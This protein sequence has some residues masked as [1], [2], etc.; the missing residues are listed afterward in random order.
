LII[1]IAIFLT[2]CKLRSELQFVQIRNSMQFVGAAVSR[3]HE[4][5]QT[6]RPTTKPTN[7]WILIMC[8]VSF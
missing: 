4:F 7:V 6:V 2:V 8:F 3:I 1:S 5:T